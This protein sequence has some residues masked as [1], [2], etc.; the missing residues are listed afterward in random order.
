MAKL[1]SGFLS[2]KKLRWT[3]VANIIGYAYITLSFEGCT[4]QLRSDQITVSSIA[5]T[6]RLIPETI[7]LVSDSGTVAIPDSDSGSFPDL[8]STIGWTV[9]GEKS[10]LRNQPLSLSTHGRVPPSK[11]R[12][13]PQIFHVMAH[14]HLHLQLL[15]LER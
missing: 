9:E 7:I 1:L 14:L 12:W 4:L 13:K 6:F 10:T 3:K 15:V 8:D 11:E 2:P 5:R